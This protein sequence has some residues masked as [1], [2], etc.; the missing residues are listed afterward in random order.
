MSINTEFKENGS[1]EADYDELYTGKKT[2]G[3]TVPKL[4]TMKDGLIRDEKIKLINGK[5]DFEIKFEDNTEMNKRFIGFG[6]LFITN[7][8]VFL[9]NKNGDQ[10]FTGFS[11]LN[12]RVVSENINKNNWIGKSTFSGSIKTFNSKLLMTKD[13]WIDIANENFQTILSFQMSFKNMVNDFRYRW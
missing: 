5:V 8:R 4:L 2:E 9:L 1:V 13:N 7:F 6:T 3:K 10:K 11:C 12:S